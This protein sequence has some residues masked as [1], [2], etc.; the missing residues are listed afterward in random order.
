M[1]IRNTVVCG[2][3][4][5]IWGTA[6]NMRDTLTKLGEQQLKRWEKAMKMPDTVVKLW[7]TLHKLRDTK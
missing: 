1:E 2:H 6:K 7:G 3:S 5:E 4:S